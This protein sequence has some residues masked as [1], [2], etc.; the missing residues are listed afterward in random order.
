MEMKLIA[1]IYANDGD[2]TGAANKPGTLLYESDSFAIAL[3][4]SVVIGGLLLETD[5][6]NGL[7][8]T[9]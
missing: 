5:S 1:R 4:N 9:V 3:F 7:I 8:S 6:I 2:S